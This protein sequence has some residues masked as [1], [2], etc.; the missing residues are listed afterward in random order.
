MAGSYLGAATIGGSVV[1]L[2]VAFTEVGDA[3][4]DLS[5]TVGVQLD[6]IGTAS[7]SINA[8]LGQ[9]TGIAGALGIVVDATLV[10]KAA[11]R[12]PATADFEAQLS[13]AVDIG[14]QLTADL[15]DPATYLT[16]LLAGL[17]NVNASLS[18]SL[19]TVQ[20]T[21]QI[22]ASAAIA[23]QLSLKIEAVDIQLV[24]LD[25]VAASI[26]AQASLIDQ[27]RAAVQAQ[28][29]AILLIQVAI[30]AAL[31]AVTGALAAYAAM[32]P[33]L[34][35]AGAYVF[36]YTGA[37]SGLGAALD[38]VT[39]ASGLSGATVVRAS[40]VLVQTSD[41][42]AVTALNAVFKVS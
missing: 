24:A 11:I 2:N 16:Q 9:L 12:I 10:A 27:V 36:L 35:T 40:L 37:L 15:T 26:G 8:A 19:P 25:S 7:A 5:T 21:G 14:A 30:A 41:T 42:A 4:S 13:A 20:L 32:A 1:G 29:S 3:L 22:T 17:A 18:A 6:R 28:V 38:A 34:A 33:Q 39:P 31:S 23:A